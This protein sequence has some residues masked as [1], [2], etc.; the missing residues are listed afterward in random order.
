FHN[1]VVRSKFGK[2]N[3]Q[4]VVKKAGPYCCKTAFHCFDVYVIT[5]ELCLTGGGYGES[6]QGKIRS[7]SAKGKRINIGDDTNLRQHKKIAGNKGPVVIKD[8]QL[9]CLRI[10]GHIWKEIISG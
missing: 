7:L 3:V 4:A 6:F 9:A 8:G 10:G 5:K 2:T 1:T